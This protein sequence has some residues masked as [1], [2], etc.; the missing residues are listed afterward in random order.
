MRLPHLDELCSVSFADLADV[1][2]RCSVLPR[3]LCAVACCLA[4][5]HV[6]IMW[7]L[8]WW[9]GRAAVSRRR[10]DYQ[11]VAERST[12]AIAVSEWYGVASPGS[13]LVLLMCQT[14]PVSRCRWKR[15]YC[16]APG[17]VP[18]GHYADY[19]EQSGG[20]ERGA[21]VPRGIK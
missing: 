21:C 4:L 11:R 17:A 2:V 12:C 5:S 1:N 3:T 16:G 19:R 20:A 13:V 7:W 10:R 15:E 6:G 8:W 9:D 18:L 14:R